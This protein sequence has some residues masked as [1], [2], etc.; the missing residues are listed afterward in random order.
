MQSSRSRNT[1]KSSLRSI[2]TDKKQGGSY[3]NF[4]NRLSELLPRFGFSPYISDLFL[5][6]F[7]SIVELQIDISQPLINYILY[8]NGMLIVASVNCKFTFVKLNN[9]LYFIKHID[10]REHL[11]RRSED[12]LLFDIITGYIFKEIIKRQYHIFIAK[13]RY[14]FLSYYK[15]NIY[16]YRYVYYGYL[17]LYADRFRTMK[18]CYI[19]MTDA[20][21]GR[22]IDDIFTYGTREDCSHVFSNYCEFVD[23]LVDIGFNDGFAHNDLHFSNLMFNGNNIV[24]LDLGR[25]LFYRY[26]EEENGSINSFLLQE[27]IKMNYNKDL[28]VIS[29]NRRS[30]SYQQTVPSSQNIQISTYKDLFSSKYQLFKLLDLY[31][32]KDDIH[33]LKC[34]FDVY[35]HILFDLITFYFNM[36]LKYIIYLQK[37]YKDEFI[38][39]YTHFSKLILIYT[40]ETIPDES[41]KFNFNLEDIIKRGGGYKYHIISDIAIKDDKQIDDI[42][43]IYKNIY[44]HYISSITNNDKK[45]QYKY[46]LDGLLLIVLLLFISEKKQRSVDYFRHPAP[47]NILQICFQVLLSFER[48]NLFFIKLKEILLNNASILIET[49]HHFF[50]KMLGISPGGSSIKQRKVKKLKNYRTT[51]GTDDFT[52]EDIYVEKKQTQSEDITHVS[53]EEADR[54]LT[55]EL[56][57][58][59]VID[60]YISMYKNKEKQDLLNNLNYQLIDER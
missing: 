22:T 31:I 8:N 11:S 59:D 58:T 45:K 9:V 23:F 30:S 35:P 28:S 42:F 1:Y 49:N 39:F 10:Y 20:I 24:V 47:I 32:P 6:S 16:D 21:Q 46:L 33:D 17:S 29:R 13:Y 37:H 53:Y 51:G 44:D 18:Q 19:C 41:I 34:G 57:T 3:D 27:I 52:S 36:Y 12:I 50:T 43:I 40:T 15:D 56:E 54:T 2:I 60:N 4:E 38:D 48:K 25:S 26:Y 55:N 7:L 5:K 14:S